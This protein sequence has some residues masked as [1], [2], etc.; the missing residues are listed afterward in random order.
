M[1]IDDMGEGMDY[2]MIADIMTL[3]DKPCGHSTVRNV[4]LR[5]ME[6]FAIALMGTYGLTGDP[7]ELAASQSF[8]NLVVSYLH[9]IYDTRA[10]KT[11]V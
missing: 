1:R 11:N 4:V 8:Q 9:E 2:R 7:A 6:K 5:V 3:N 10:S